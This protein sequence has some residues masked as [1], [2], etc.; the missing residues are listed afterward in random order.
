MVCSTS[1]HMYIANWFMCS[2][3]ALAFVQISSHSSHC[4]LP[5]MADESDL[6]SLLLEKDHP[7]NLKSMESVMRAYPTAAGVQLVVL[8]CSQVWFRMQWVPVKLRGDMRFPTMIW[9]ICDQ[10]RERQNSLE[11][12]N[13]WQLAGKGRQCQDCQRKTPGKAMLMPRTIPIMQ[14]T[15]ALDIVSETWAPR[16]CP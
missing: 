5:Q 4:L 9:Q 11:R 2:H 14:R 16:R 3:P 10:R 7:G 13:R 15:H 8:L 1:V 12:R 6:S